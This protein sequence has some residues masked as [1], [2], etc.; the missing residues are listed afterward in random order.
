M[1]PWTWP[2][3]R[4][5]PPLPDQRSLVDGVGESQACA[6]APF[7]AARERHGDRTGAM[8]RGTVPQGAAGG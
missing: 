3:Q 5:C 8:E 1:G 6:G 7:P 4:L 2:P